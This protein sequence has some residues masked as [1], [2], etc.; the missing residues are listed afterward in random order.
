VASAE[1]EEERRA[2]G[3]GSV[4]PGTWKRCGKGAFTAEQALPMVAAG[5]LGGWD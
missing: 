4:T 3:R 5:S 1:E 2:R